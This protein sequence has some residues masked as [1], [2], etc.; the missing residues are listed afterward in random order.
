MPVYIVVYRIASEV[1]VAIAYGSDEVARSAAAVWENVSPR[2]NVN[3]YSN[4][5]TEGN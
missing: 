5:V 1:I 2:H 4:V 3:L